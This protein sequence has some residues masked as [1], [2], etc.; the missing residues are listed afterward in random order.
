[1][2]NTGLLSP[3]TI[4]IQ[5]RSSSCKNQLPKLPPRAFGGVTIYIK[6]KT[7]LGFGRNWRKLE[8]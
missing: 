6:L 3:I 1:M 2:N 7:K 4:T 5:Y 8:N